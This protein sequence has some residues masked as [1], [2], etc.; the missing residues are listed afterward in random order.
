MPAGEPSRILVVDDTPEITTSLRRLLAR[1]GHDVQTASNGPEAIEAAR[2]WGA[3][4]IL[5][6]YQMPGMN[7]D[8]VVAAIRGFDPTVQIVIMTGHEGDRP[9]RDLMQRLDIQGF[10]EKSAGAERLLLHVDAA[11]KAYAHLSV[12]TLQ[13]AGMRRILDAAPLVHLV[14][15]LQTLAATALQKALGLDGRDPSSRSGFVAFVEEEDEGPVLRAKSGVFARHRNWSEIPEQARG[16]CETALA[17]GSI[18][19]TQGDFI[20]IPLRAV[21]RTVGAFGIQAGSSPSLT[22]LLLLFASQVALAV[23]N[24]RLHDLATVDSLTGL[25]AR[26]HFLQRV[27]EWAKLSARDGHPLSLL[28]VD[29]DGLKKV[30]DA[31]G[32]I[33]GDLAL[34]EVGSRI[35]SGIRDTDIAGRYGGDEFMVLTPHTGPAGAAIVAERIRVAICAPPVQ[36]EGDTVTLSASISFGGFDRMPVP[37]WMRQGG[38]RGRWEDLC[39]W[40][41]AAVDEALYAAKGAGRNCVVAAGHDGNLD[42]AFRTFAER[43]RS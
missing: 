18:E 23:E 41:I 43:L 25:Y 5:L 12:I 16:L 6:D 13:T 35:R 3:H 14:Q 4:C 33:A 30:N 36:F 24:L 32:H 9:A 1:E 15:P 22:G 39:K 17:S 42:S 29:M 27:D 11:L 10:H 28:V 37:A 8:D 26:R 21:D 38:T 19:T 7:G 20:A 2:S 40:L 34:A 31:Y